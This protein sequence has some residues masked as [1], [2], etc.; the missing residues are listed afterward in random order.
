MEFRELTM[1][2]EDVLHKAVMT[3]QREALGE[4]EDETVEDE[5]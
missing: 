2:Q 3:L 1:A 5:G 4:G